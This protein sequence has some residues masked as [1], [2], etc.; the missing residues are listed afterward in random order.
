VDTPGTA[1]PSRVIAATVLFSDIRNFT[2]LADRLSPGEVAELLTVYFERS[3]ESVLQEGGCHLK[4]IGDGLMAVFTDAAGEPGV[5]AARR[6]VASALSLAHAA[7]G[8]GGWIA[9]RFG[10]RALPAFAIGVGLHLGEVA[11]CRPGTLHER[12]STA[13]GDTVNVAA[14]LEASSKALGWTVVASGAVLSAAGEG[15]VT[16]GRTRVD[17]RGKSGQIEVAEIL[18]LRTAGRHG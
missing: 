7:P 17:I 16:G 6:A 9:R 1:A 4:F 15:V 11:L 2:A 5:P 13:V 10:P 18:G 3:C 12:E 14:R 8:F